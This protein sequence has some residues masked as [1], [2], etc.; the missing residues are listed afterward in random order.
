MD[1]G[2]GKWLSDR[3]FKCYC[4]FPQV[5]L[6]RDAWSLEM[7]VWEAAGQGRWGKPGQAKAVA[8]RLPRRRWLSQRWEDWQGW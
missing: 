5:L 7:G 6:S 4:A 1:W 2:W 3:C 8:L